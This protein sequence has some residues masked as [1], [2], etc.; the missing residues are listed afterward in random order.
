MGWV[1]GATSL[2]TAQEKALETCALS[3]VTNCRLYAQDLSVVWGANPP[4]PPP[5]PPG[6]L[7]SGM[8]YSFV[9]DA[10]FFWY[11]PQAAR[12][13]IVWAHGRDMQE[14]RGAQPPDYVRVFN[15]AGFDVVRFDRAPLND[16]VDNAD[17]WLHRG[18]AA[19]RGMG[20]RMI[21]AAGQSRG[22][23][24]DLQVLDTPGLVDAVIAISP[25]ANGTDPGRVNLAGQTELW[26]IA[27]AAHAPQA[28]V[29]IAQF[30]ADPF[31]GNE[32]ERRATLE[33]QLRPSVGALLLIDRPS[34]FEGHGG[35]NTSKFALQFDACLYR[36]V[37]SAEP[38]GPC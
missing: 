10:R 33:A 6:A 37:T 25:A 17:R 8:G 28:R 27:H 19:L 2:A 5:P 4:P 14:D 13:V 23:W 29:V 31:A 26:S 20:W 24:N 16:D 9:P 18:L 11:P 35:G 38:P 30:T 21:V 32:D 1:A 7:I 3:G 36:F 22:A 15:N 34:G 12:G